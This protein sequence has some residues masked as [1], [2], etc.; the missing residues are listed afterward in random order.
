MKAIAADALSIE[1]LGNGVVID[2]RIMP[3]VKRRI[4]AGDLGKLRKARQQSADRRQIVR[5]VKGSKRGQARDCEDLIV[6]QHRPA[7]VWAA[8]DDAMANRN[9]REI[10]VS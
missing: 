8:M 10:W 3:P 7:I 4:E 2:D 9:R 1:P 5:L 6:D